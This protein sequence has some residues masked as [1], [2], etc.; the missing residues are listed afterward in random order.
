MGITAS[1]GGGNLEGYTNQMTMIRGLGSSDDE[2]FRL[3]HIGV[4]VD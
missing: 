1:I 3:W 2:G 4:V